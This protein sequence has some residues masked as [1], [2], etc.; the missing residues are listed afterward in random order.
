MI[1]LLTVA[2][3]A[4]VA[5]SHATVI[6]LDRSAVSE[7]MDAMQQ[8][9]M[10]WPDLER[11]WNEFKELYKKTYESTMS[12][13][14]RRMIWLS[15]LVHI[16]KHNEAFE[17]GKKTYKVEMNEYADIT[18]EE[19]FKD[20][21]GYKHSLKVS[22]ADK[23][24]HTRPAT[25]L[26]PIGYD[27]SSLDSVEKHLPKSVDWRKEGFV[28]PVKNQGQCGSCWSFSATGALEG[29][30]MRKLGKLPSLSEQNLI[31]CSR[32]EGNM[33]CNGGLMDNAFDYIKHQ[34]GIDSEDSYEYETRDDQ[35]CRYH[36]EDKAGDD[37][38]YVDIPSFSEKHLKSALA[39]EGPVAVAIDAA[40]RSFQF[41][42]SGIYYEPDCS[43][44]QL[45]H[46]VL[47]V[48]YGDACDDEGDEAKELCE[49]GKSKYYIVKNS[50]GPEWG[51][52][53]FIK[54]AAN[55]QNH[56]GIATA[57]SYPLV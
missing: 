50:W 17:A 38:G 46:G 43:S 52:G 44:E 21:N 18:S 48:G 12:E 14:R 41:Y 47:A 33:G 24:S 27:G 40:H 2:A 10:Q 8:L 29:Q 45:D 26:L 35:P 37:V 53:G 20:R 9:N 6:E 56:C 57:A 49:S 11:A 55:R 54:M 7:Q 42:S 13:N 51:D 34:D 15:N 16:N 25:Y 31:D 1:K 32:R 28:T 3:V 22:A 23:P 5:V 39:N 30:M 19:F 36:V 4:A